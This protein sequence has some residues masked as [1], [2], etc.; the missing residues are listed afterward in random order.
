MPNGG[1]A[2]QGTTLVSPREMRDLP[3][4]IIQVIASGKQGAVGANVAVVQDTGGASIRCGARVRT[5]IQCRPQPGVKIVIAKR[6]LKCGESRL[7]GTVP[8]SDVV[9][10]V[11]VMQGWGPSFDS[12]V[13]GHP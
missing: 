5:Q 10:F 11:G 3:S 4:T 6:P 13:L 2:F 7:A 1:T 12:G 9:H 8:G